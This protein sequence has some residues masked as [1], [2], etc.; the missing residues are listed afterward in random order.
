MHSVIWTHF[1]SPNS[2]QLVC[3]FALCVSI[4][5]LHT[6]SLISYKKKINFGDC[7]TYFNKIYQCYQVALSREVPAVSKLQ[8]ACCW[9]SLIMLRVLKVTSYNSTDQGSALTTCGDFIT[10]LGNYSTAVY[11]STL[12]PSTMNLFELKSSYFDNTDP[13]PHYQK[14][15]QS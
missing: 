12:R 8:K 7:W 2:A 13:L 5:W 6:V 4:S 3:K 9:S 10:L 11:M 1:P 14:Q 15:C